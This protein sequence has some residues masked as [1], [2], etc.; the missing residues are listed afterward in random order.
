M[1]RD[2]TK[3]SINGE[4]RYSKSKL[5]L[6]IVKEYIRQNP[7]ETLEE[8]DF[9]IILKSKMSGFIT[10][11]EDIK[12]F[13]RYSKEILIDSQNVKFQVSNQWNTEAIEEL[14]FFAG[15]Q[16]IEVEKLGEPNDRGTDIVPPDSLNASSGITVKFIIRNGEG[17]D[18]IDACPYLHVNTNVALDLNIPLTTARLLDIKKSIISDQETLN[19]IKRELSNYPLTYSR[20]PQLW[21]GGIDEIDLTCVLKLYFDED[22][23]QESIVNDIMV[24]EEYDL[25]EYYDSDGIYS[26]ETIMETQ[27]INTVEK[28]ESNQIFNLSSFEV[29]KIAKL[30]S[31]QEDDEASL[32]KI[33]EKIE[34]LLDEHPKY[35]ILGKLFERYG[36]NYQRDDVDEFFTIGDD[37]ECSASELL[38]LLKE[39]SLLPRIIQREGI[40]HETLGPKNVNFK[41]LFA[42][43]FIKSLELLVQLD[44]NE[45]LAEFIVNQSILTIEDDYKVESSMGDWI[46]DLT[47]EL[48]EHI[49]GLDIIDFD[50]ECEIDGIYFGRAESM[51]YDYHSYAQ[52]IIDGLI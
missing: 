52:E 49:Y 37:P 36:Y 48:I 6:E 14:I 15:L 17:G 23:D 18:E 32:D 5:A 44:N 38:E 22:P 10:S 27:T 43:Y 33:D 11:V 34:E 51:G 42:A 28:E 13:K 35:F 8:L 20:Y 47:T 7:E 46:A 3:Y 25:E 30:Y 21:L 1:A 4:G 19:A 41:L 29:P 31:E 16:G 24:L 39:E 9:S 40:E 50:G 26:V 12:D 2:Y 45:M